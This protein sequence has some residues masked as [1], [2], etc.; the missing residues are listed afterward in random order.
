MVGSL[1]DVDLA[2]TQGRPPL[3]LSK[4]KTLKEVAFS[5][6]VNR[7]NHAEWVNATLSTISSGHKDLQRVSIHA[8]LV[9]EATRQELI[10][11]EETLSHISKLHAV[12]TKVECAYVDDWQPGR[13][14]TS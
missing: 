10:K 13:I 3:D 2:P 12:F 6:E 8:T 7:H 1:S 9:G 5:F 4:A 11:L 14:S